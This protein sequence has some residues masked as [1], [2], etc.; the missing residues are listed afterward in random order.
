MTDIYLSDMSRCEPASALSSR[1]ENGKWLLTD[2]ATEDG[3]AGST[4]Y[5]TPET[6]PPAVSLALGQKGW[7][8]IYIGV[9]YTRSIWQASDATTSGCLRV[10]LD[11]EEQYTPVM[12]EA[13]F[14]SGYPFSTEAGLFEEK[15]GELHDAWNCI[16]EVY[17]KSAQLDGSERIVFCPPAPDTPGGRTVSNIAWVRMRP[18]TNADIEATNRDRPTDETRRLAAMVCL[19]D[20]TGNTAGAD[21]YHPTDEAYMKEKLAVYTENDF[22]IVMLECIRGDVCAY[23]SK[24]G[25]VGVENR[26]NP[27][28]IDPLEVAVE[29]VHE[30][31]LELY[32]TARMA[33]LGRPIQRSPL[34][35]NLYYRKN[36]RFAVLDEEGTPC[37]NL[38]LAFPEVRQRW[39]DLYREAVRY[40][41]DGAHLL[42]IR[43]EPFV[44]YEEPSVK[45]FEEKYGED[46][47]DLPFDDPRWLQHRAGYLT[48][49]MRQMRRMLDEEGSKQGRRLGMSASFYFHPSPTYYAMD[50]VTWAKEGLV[51]YLLPMNDLIRTSVPMPDSL[52]FWSPHVLTFIRGLKRATKGTGVKIY[53]DAMGLTPSGEAYARR[54]MELYGSGADG[55]SFWTPEGR[56]KRASEAAI[57]A[58]LGHVNELKRYRQLA[59]TYWRR[60]PLKMLGGLSQRYSYSD[61]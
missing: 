10:R 6:R 53:P 41:A 14:S 28:W 55:L 58:R 3:I 16:Y 26:W 59:G 52:G 4:I 48:E 56:M 33:G 7:F 2:Y 50:P 1:L 42:F 19:V 51:D 9:N 13:S 43:S 39:I 5:A 37:S 35:E 27:K 46:P 34:M 40:G 21:P 29:F 30:N 36:R 32:V 17:W 61:G 49:Y 12:S 38:S 18:M 15:T 24:I 47:R 20:L 44:L 8:D 11:S 54:A 23:H 57:V 31:G 22:H 45:T 60:V 25:R